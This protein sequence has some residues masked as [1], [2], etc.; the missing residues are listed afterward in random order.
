MSIGRLQQVVK[1]FRIKFPKLGLIAAEIED[2]PVIVKILAPSDF[3]LDISIYSRL[4]EAEWKFRLAFDW[5]LVNVIN[6]QNVQKTYIVPV[7]EMFVL[8][9]DADVSSDTESFVSSFTDFLYYTEVC[10]EIVENF[11]LHQG[12]ASECCET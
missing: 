1:S 8:G 3:E 10:K 11:Q 7:Q 2:I 5:P 9:E 4:T 12:E 6:C